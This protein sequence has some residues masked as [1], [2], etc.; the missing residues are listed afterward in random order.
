MNDSRIRQNAGGSV[1]PLLMNYTPATRIEEMDEVKIS[2][3]DILQITEI[4]VR[5]VGTRSL[6]ISTTRKMV[7][8]PVKKPT[9][10]ADKKNEI[11]DS[12][13]VK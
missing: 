12:K 5:T 3:N 13:N 4:E 10:V 7:G 1:M 11:D 8:H 6:K 9:S 2:Y